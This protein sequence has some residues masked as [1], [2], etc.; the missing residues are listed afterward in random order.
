[1]ARI[2]LALAGCILLAV[3]TCHAEDEQYVCRIESK[4]P[5]SGRIEF[6][7]FKIKGVPGVYTALHG[8]HGANQ[9]DAIFHDPKT[10]RVRMVVSEVDIARDTALLVPLDD[11]DALPAGGLGLGVWP[12]KHRLEGQLAGKPATVIGYPFGIDLGCATTQLTIRKPPVAE[13]TVLLNPSARKELAQRGSPSTS[14]DML[15]LQGPFLPGHSGAP[16]LDADGAVIGIGIGGLGEGKVGHGWATPFH[17]VEL[18]PVSDAT[19]NA[20]LVKLPVHRATYSF[21]LVADEAA[22]EKPDRKSLVSTT[23][24]SGDGTPILALRRGP[25]DEIKN[26]LD[27]IA[28]ILKAIRAGDNKKF[29]AAGEL[30]RIMQNRI[31]LASGTAVEVLADPEMM[32][33]PADIPTDER[34]M[35]NA[36][37][38]LY[39][40]VRIVDGTAKDE[41]LW[42]PTIAIRRRAGNVTV[43]N[44]INVRENNGT[45]VGAGNRGTV[46]GGDVV[47]N[48]LPP[49]RKRNVLD[50]DGSPTLVLKQLGDDPLD[51]VIELDNHLGLAAVGTEVRVLDEKKAVNP[52]LVFRKVE[53]LAGD[54]KGKTGWVSQN[55]IRLVES[56]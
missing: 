24:E 31:Y 43:D 40:K 55:C 7:G 14:V 51:S 37:S 25:G 19:V 41:E 26:E 28:E 10:R 34:N 1:M 9:V 56:R 53:I 29:T 35:R 50:N 16:I 12:P 30:D 15:S 13:L 36:M 49:V 42:V 17:E 45:I 48:P 46:I 21:F 3:G 27:R 5:A 33:L 22:R 11:A 4:L 52:F 2:T 18:L 20:Q 39:T 47:I 23:I 44:S 32:K 8:V 54:L 38:Q 6:T